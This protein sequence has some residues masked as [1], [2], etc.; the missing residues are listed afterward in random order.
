MNRVPVW[1][2]YIL[3]CCDGSVYVRS[4]GD[5]N[6]RIRVHH[7]GNGPAYTAKWLPIR[8]VY[9]KQ[10][11]TLQDAV[12][13]ERQLKGWSRANKAALVAGDREALHALSKRRTNLTTTDCS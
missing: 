6:A 12:I 13:R 5:L 10:H 4:T 8:L 7:S 3:E 1:R 11:S 2:S 9:S